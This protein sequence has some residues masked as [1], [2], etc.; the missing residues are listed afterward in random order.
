M[1]IWRNAPDRLLLQSQDPLT[2]ASDGALAVSDLSDARVGLE[3]KGLGAAGMLARVTALN[4]APNSFASGCF[5]QTALHHISVLIER[6]QTDRFDLL[7]PTYWA[8]S[9]IEIL[10]EHIIIDL[11]ST[12]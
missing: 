8:Q 7:V 2:V 4:Y 12:K 1:R 11:G 6:K 5:A 9:V 10:A 3:I